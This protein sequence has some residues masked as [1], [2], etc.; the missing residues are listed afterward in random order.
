MR[1]VA[2]ALPE[3]THRLFVLSAQ[4]IQRLDPVFSS[5][6]VI[7]LEEAL[8]LTIHRTGKIRVRTEPSPG[9]SAS[10]AVGQR[11][12]AARLA[13][14]WTQQ[15]LAD[16]SGIARAN[17]ARMEAGKHAPRVETIKVV[18]QALSLAM[19]D[20]FKVPGHSPTAEDKDWAGAGVSDWSAAL[21]QEDQP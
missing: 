20:L 9:M 12:R 19:A 10:W 3:R 18:A 1:I 17:I 7:P 4:V 16:H 11:I 8:G 6:A 5:D 14:G 21:S 15:D 2:A 13:K